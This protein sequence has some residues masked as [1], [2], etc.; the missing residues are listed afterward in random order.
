MAI[1]K[2]CKKKYT[3]DV[4][5][6]TPGEITEVDAE[7]PADALVHGVSVID[8][9]PLS[10]AYKYFGRVGAKLVSDGK[11]HWIE[12]NQRKFDIF[13]VDKEY[14]NDKQMKTTNINT[15]YSDEANKRALEEEIGYNSFSGKEDDTEQN[16]AADKQEYAGMLHDMVK[17]DIATKEL[18]R[19]KLKK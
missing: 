5:G 14:S 1:C 7:S 12:S 16:I 3:F 4:I 10:S 9:I 18:E 19:E 2:N 17:D 15:V 13:L 11:Y 8:G 6:P